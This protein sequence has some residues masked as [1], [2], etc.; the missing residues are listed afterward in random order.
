MKLTVRYASLTL[1]AIRE[2]KFLK[3]NISKDGHMKENILI[4][5]DEKDILTTLNLLLE[6]EGYSVTCALNGEEAMVRFREKTF[7]LILTDIRMPVMDGLEL[8]RK[9]KEADKETEVIVLTGHG[10]LENAIGALKDGGAFDFLQKPLNDIDHLLISVSHALERRRLRQQV[11]H[12]QK[13]EAIA[14]VA[15][16][17]AHE[18]NNTLSG[19]MG[20]V[21]LLELHLAGNA[22]P[23]EYTKKIKPICLR[24]SDLSRQLLTY[25]KG[26]QYYPFPLSFRSLLEKELPKIQ[27]AVPPDI[28]I[29]KYCLYDTDTVKADPLQIQIVLKE[30]IRNAAEAMEG[31]KGRIRVVLEECVSGNISSVLAKPA[32]R[33]YLCLTVADDG[34]GMDEKTKSRIFDPFFSTKFAGRGMGMA[35]V[36]GIIQKHDGDILVES[37]PGRG[38][39]IKIYLPLFTEQCFVMAKIQD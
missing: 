1:P 14:T 11:L 13:T 31:K 34:K 10:T 7:D 39:K 24:M 38:T 12:S 32:G 18:F 9:V 19:V 27:S 17:I 37:E 5:D 36:Y 8:L 6:M 26:G 28:E 20:Y 3:Y 30:L 15:A 23:K 33:K 35:T 16:G 22:K 21:D 2:M 25:A 29:E 4:V